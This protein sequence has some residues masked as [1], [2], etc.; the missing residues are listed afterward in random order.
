M[1][2]PDPKNPYSSPAFP[3]AAPAAAVAGYPDRID[4]MRA[5][6]YIFENPN[7]TMNVMWG[8]L[9]L[10]STTVIPVLGQL[11]FMGYS[12]EVIEALCLSRGTRYPDFDLNRFGDYLARSIWPFLVNLLVAIPLII[13]F[14]I[15]LIIT[16]LLAA[17]GGAAGGDKFGPVLAILL[18]GIGFLGLTALMLV[19][20]GLMLPMLLRAGLMQEFAA[21]FDMT[22]AMDFLKKTWVEIVLS[23]LFLM[24]TGIVLELLGL[25]A[26]CVGLFAAVAVVGLAFSHLCYQLYMVYLGRGGIPLPLKPAPV[27]VMPPLPP[28][29][30]PMPPRY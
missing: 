8:F 9:C 16:V 6:N 25:C 24:A 20:G 7:W 22:W 18:G 26:L 10:I 1:S 11:V 4:Y 28:A 2:Y 14:Y 23:Y 30:P 13:V 17:A 19:A 3:V 27:A 5:Y 21:A 12:Y 29:A 15:G